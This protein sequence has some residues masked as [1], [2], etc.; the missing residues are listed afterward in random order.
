MSSIGNPLPTHRLVGV[1]FE[2]KL[3]GKGLVIIFKNI[4]NKQILRVE[5]YEFI[6]H[7]IT[8]SNSYER[9]FKLNVDVDGKAERIHLSKADYN[10]LSVLLAGYDDDVSAKPAATVSNI[11]QRV[12]KEFAENAKGVAGRLGKAFSIEEFVKAMNDPKQE[13]TGH[14][15]RV[16]KNTENTNKRIERKEKMRTTA[17]NEGRRRGGSRVVPPSFNEPKNVRQSNKINFRS[18]QD[19]ISMT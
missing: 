11:F 6:K 8:F 16:V 9:T 18:Y 4:E 3:R 13:T 19:F 12:A 14:I 1:C 5:E 2:T 10:R 17:G 7:Q 15:A